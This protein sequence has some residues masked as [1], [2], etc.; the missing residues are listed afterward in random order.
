MWR[1]CKGWMAGIELGA[2][3][4]GFVQGGGGESG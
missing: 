2:F 3:A 4:Q 1:C